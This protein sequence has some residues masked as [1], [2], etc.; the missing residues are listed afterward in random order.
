MFLFF[1]RGDLID[2]HYVDTVGKFIWTKNEAEEISGGWIFL[3]LAYHY[4]AKYTNKKGQFRTLLT[5]FP[6]HHASTWVC[7]PKSPGDQ[8]QSLTLIEQAIDCH[9]TFKNSYGIKLFQNSPLLLLSTR[10]SISQI[11]FSIVIWGNSNTTTSNRCFTKTA[12]GLNEKSY[13]NYL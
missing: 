7:S 2:A 10:R 8:L 13:W 12:L 9:M 6:K 5:L 1:F 4:D 3:A 11:I